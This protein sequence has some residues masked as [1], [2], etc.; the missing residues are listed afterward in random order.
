MRWQDEREE[1]M[2]AEIKRPYAAP[3]LDGN[4]A[5]LT[6]LRVAE[7][8]TFEVLTEDDE[9]ISRTLAAGVYPP[10]YGFLIELLRA[11]TPTGGRVLDLGAHV[12]IFSLAAAAAGFEVI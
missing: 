7:N 2:D 3:P 1:A 4:K 9:P 10:E 6:T 12:G 5:A 8:V 11:I